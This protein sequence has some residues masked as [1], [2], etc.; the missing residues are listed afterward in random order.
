[1]KL[2]QRSLDRIEKE[3][4]AL[5]HANVIALLETYSGREGARV[6]WDILE[7]SNGS[8]KKVRHYVQTAQQDYRDILYWAEYY[9]KDPMIKG[10]HPKKVVD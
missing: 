4:P 6:T 8:S 1:M 3:F 10:R 9:D 2:E 7:L 5:E